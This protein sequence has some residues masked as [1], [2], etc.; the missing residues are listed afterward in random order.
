MTHDPTRTGRVEGVEL[1]GITHPTGA[2]QCLV[3]WSPPHG[4]RLGQSDTS[5]RGEDCGHRHTGVIN[6]TL[7]SG[8]IVPSRETPVAERTMCDDGND[9]R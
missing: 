4:T 7:W 2:L 5:A 8:V 3:P 6:L 9:G 1:L